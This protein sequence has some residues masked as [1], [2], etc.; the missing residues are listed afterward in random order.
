MVDIEQEY[1]NDMDKEI[2]DFCIKN[3]PEEFEK[4]SKDEIT[5][6]RD[7]ETLEKIIRIASESNRRK[8][9][10]EEKF[11]RINFEVNKST[12]YWKTLNRR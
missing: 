8:E 1:L 11:K 3:F 10:K 12:E 9:T 7:M 6:I 2:F 5:K 4:Q